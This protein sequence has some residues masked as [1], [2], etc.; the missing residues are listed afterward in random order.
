MGWTGDGEGEVEGGV[1]LMVM[2]FWYYGFKDV[3]FRD[4]YLYASTHLDL[5][6]E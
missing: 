6:V 1:G 3:Y 2:A 4:D 5:E